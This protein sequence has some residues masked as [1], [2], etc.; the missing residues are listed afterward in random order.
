MA[1]HQAPHPDAEMLH[2]MVE[3]LR[4]A[5]HTDDQQAVTVSL[6]AEQAD[7]MAA[8]LEHLAQ[9]MDPKSEKGKK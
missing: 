6:P 8:A 2:G 7:A 1:D 9:G 3:Q 5:P 4:S